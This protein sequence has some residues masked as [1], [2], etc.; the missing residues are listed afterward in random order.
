MTVVHGT[1]IIYSSPNSETDWTPVKPADVPSWIKDDPE[2]L[3]RLVENGEAACDNGQS[4]AV[5][6]AA[7]RVLTETEQNT[8]R[9]AIEKRMRRNRLRLVKSGITVAP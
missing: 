6:Y 5:W 1:L 9:A 8:L 3:G 4:P 7:Q 2:V